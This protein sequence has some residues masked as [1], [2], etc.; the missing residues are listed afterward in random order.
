MSP[1]FRGVVH[2]KHCTYV[3]TSVRMENVV[4]VSYL[5]RGG[6]GTHARHRPPISHLGT[7]KKE[8]WI[9]NIDGYSQR[10]LR[11]SE[12]TFYNMVS[13]L[14]WLMQG[15]A[16]RGRHVI[17]PALSV[18]LLGAHAAKF[19]QPF[20]FGRGIPQA[21]RDIHTKYA[22]GNA[23]RRYRCCLPFPFWTSRVC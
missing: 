11:D 20:G 4:G 2:G 10:P 6:G 1:P 7:S 12:V 5:L 3:R 14:Q 9:I 13:D 19:H 21:L 16:R 15:V 22:S 17:L 23:G 8:K 18:L